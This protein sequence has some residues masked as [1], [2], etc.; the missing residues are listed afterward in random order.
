MAGLRGFNRV[1]G[2]DARTRRNWNAQATA[3]E[4]RSLGFGLELDTAKLLAV[5]LDD[6]GLPQESHITLLAVAPE[7]TAF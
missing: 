3:F 2:R 5:A 4:D 7:F 1:P 6:L